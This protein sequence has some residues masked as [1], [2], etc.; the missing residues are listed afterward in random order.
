ME[1]V[2]VVISKKR[3][4]ARIYPVM[5]VV[6]QSARRLG[7]VAGCFELGA[8]V[9]GWTLQRE[10]CVVLR[11]VCCCATTTAAKQYCNCLGGSGV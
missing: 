2:R 5:I 7:D 8:L 6:A 10:L 1:T 9:Q 3:E 11:V 4:S